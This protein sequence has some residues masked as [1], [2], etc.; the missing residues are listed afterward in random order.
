MGFVIRFWGVR[1]SIACPSPQH[2]VYGG[3]TACVEVAAGEARIILDA[4]TGI[5]GLGVRL[6]QEDA[7]RA[8]L[9]L[10]HT[11]WDHISGFPF[12]KMSLIASVA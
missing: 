1:G 5:R 9:L 3:N 6:L 11:H 12:F 7:R 8:Q 4:G 2:M 10:S